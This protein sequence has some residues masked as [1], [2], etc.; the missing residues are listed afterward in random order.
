M[1]GTQHTTQHGICGLRESFR[2]GGNSFYSR[3]TAGK[4]NQQQLHQ[5]T[6]ITPQQFVCTKITTKLR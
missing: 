5:M 6:Q 4:R 1:P 2:F 3:S